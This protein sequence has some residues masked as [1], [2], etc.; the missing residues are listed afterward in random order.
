MRSVWGPGSWGLPARLGPPA[1]TPNPDPKWGLRPSVFP[2][3]LG[4]PAS[5]ASS[6]AFEGVQQRV[7]VVFFG[8]AFFL[9]LI[10]VDPQ[11]PWKSWKKGGD[12]KI[13]SFPVFFPII[14]SFYAMFL[15]QHPFGFPVVQCRFGVFGGGQSAIL[16]G[17]DPPNPFDR[18]FKFRF[19]FSPA[20][21]DFFSRVRGF[22]RFTPRLR[23]DRLFHL[24]RRDP[25][26]LC[27]K[28]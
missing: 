11:A 13:L 3:T 19:P 24:W 26:P 28:S 25:L 7:I 20:G 18:G 23:G 5:R 9:V 21:S 17:P 10:L 2:G 6:G 27:F 1:H 15:G 22:P 12:V 16:W 4:V 14:C 8:G